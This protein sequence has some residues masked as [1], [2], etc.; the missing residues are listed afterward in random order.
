MAGVILVALQP[1]R[2]EL[3][4]ASFAAIGAGRELATRFGARLVLG[5]VASNPDDI[6]DR[7]G[8]EG[9][10]EIVTS[11]VVGDGF[12]PDAQEAAV[13]ALGHHTGAL[14][15]LFAHTVD[16][17]AVAPAIAAKYELGLATDVIDVG[18]CDGDVT[19]VRAS[20]G[21]KIHERMQFPHACVV[22]TVR[23]STFSPPP[24]T[25]P[26]SIPVSNIEREE[27]ELRTTHTEWIDPAS[28]GIDITKSDFL[29]SVGRAIGSADNVARVDRLATSLGG[30]MSASRPVIDSGWAEPSRQVGQTGKTVKPKVYLALGISGAVQHLAGMANS[31]TVIAVNTDP[32]A[33]I[34]GVAD[35]TAEIDIMELIEALEEAASPASI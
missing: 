9:V 32:N 23:A 1:R 16:A 27:T 26:A 4:D 29:L 2:G 8:F 18:M 10:D 3:L 17:M 25:S 15:I 5:V 19:A 21:G 31:D 11:E 35:Y 24:P 14:A 34:F 6:L 22:L 13:L 20:F 33:P 7:L 28:G 30:V 12:D